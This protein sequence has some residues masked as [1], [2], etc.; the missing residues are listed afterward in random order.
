MI[1]VVIVGACHRAASGIYLPL[2][3]ARMQ[4]FEKPFSR[5]L[6]ENHGVDNVCWFHCPAWSIGISD[7]AVSE[8]GPIAGESGMRYV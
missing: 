6:G 3:T 2:S 8:A 7:V 5:L 1:F 4:E